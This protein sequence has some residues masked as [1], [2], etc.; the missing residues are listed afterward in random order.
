[1]KAGSR[2]L[3]L[4]GVIALLNALA[5]CGGGSDAAIDHEATAPAGSFTGTAYLK[6]RNT[7]HVNGKEYGVARMGVQTLVDQ[8][9]GM[10]E[11]FYGLPAVLPSEAKMASLDVSIH[12]KYFDTDKALTL[13]TAK[14]AELPDLQRWTG[15]AVAI[16]KSGS[17]PG[18]PP[19]CS[20][21]HEKEL[22]SGTLWR[23]GVKYRLDFNTSKAIASRMPDPDAKMELATESEYLSFPTNSYGG[24]TCREVPPPPGLTSATTACMWD[25]FP[26]M[27]YLNW[28]FMLK[29]R[30]Q[31][32]PDTG[33]DS[34]LFET[35]ETLVVERDGLIVPL[36]FDVPAGFKVIWID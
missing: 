24:Q 13:I 9:N 31:F 5:A 18:V 32:G 34:T 35:V 17:Y 10:R 14:S 22:R 16:S 30:I 4:A 6:T 36:L 12:E 27:S 25:R 29:G 15:E 7:V 19:D 21:M 26:F 20:D 8:C 3:A 33:P 28:P 11:V 1:M 2:L 23:D